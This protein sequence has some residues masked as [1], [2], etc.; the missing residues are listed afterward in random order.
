MSLGHALQVDSVTFFIYY[1]HGR[2]NGNPPTHHGQVIQSFNQLRFVPVQNRM[3][4][5]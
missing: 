3:Y 2:N 4:G 1:T 5:I